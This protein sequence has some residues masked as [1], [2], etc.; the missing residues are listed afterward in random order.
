MSFL[1]VYA[2]SEWVGIRYKM[3]TI[4]RLNPIGPHCGMEFCVCV[5]VRVGVCVSCYKKFAL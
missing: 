1:N 3:Q 5:C 2:V 4:D